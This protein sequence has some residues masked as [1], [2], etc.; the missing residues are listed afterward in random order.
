MEYKERVVLNISVIALL[1]Q[2]RPFGRWVWG[3][4]KRFYRLHSS[5]L[6]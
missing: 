3:L 2:N 1:L 4:T 5:C 6:C